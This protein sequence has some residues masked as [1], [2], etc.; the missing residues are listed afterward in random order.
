MV[1]GDFVASFAGPNPGYRPL[2]MTRRATLKRTVA[3]FREDN[4]TDWAAALTYYAVLSIFP[5]L[6]VFVA[7]IG[8][9][10]QD[11]QT[12]DA[13][14]KIV[15]DV[16]SQSTA[17]SVHGTIENVIGAKGGAGAL[18]GIGLLGAVWTASGYIGA[19]IRAINAIYEVREG[20]PFWKLRPLQIAMTLV[21]VLGVALIAIALVTTGTLARAIGDQVGLGDTAVTIWS[22]AKWPVML[23]IVSQLFAGL[24]YL[25]P[26]VRQ[27]G[28]R[29]ITPG[30]A[31]AVAI[32]VTASA[33]FSLYV[34]HFGSYDRT[35]GSLGAA[36]TF[37][38]WLWI[39]NLALL[40]GAELDA[41]LERSRELAAG[42]PAQDQILLP[43]REPA[44]EDAPATTG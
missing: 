15:A 16:S 14:T 22:I 12:V 27:P 23:V 44:D 42:E 7:F 17:N 18:L 29:W 33:G 10:G 39:T 21:A 2:A 37:L 20:R 28:F 43:P 40:F 34:S 9:V 32:W 25:A 38:V 6:I 13:I 26:N 11:P 1:G 19:F 35:Y 4:L 8:L 24:Y 36:V 41:E 30:G 31:V 3:E 5:A